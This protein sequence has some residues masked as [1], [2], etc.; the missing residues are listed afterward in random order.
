MSLLL[1]YNRS[2]DATTG[3]DFGTRN[4]SVTLRQ[5]IYLDANKRKMFRILRVMMSPEIPNVYNNGGIDTTKINL[6]NDDGATWVTCLLKTGVYTIGMLN[7][8]INNVAELQNWWKTAGDFGYE[9]NYNPATKMVYVKLDSSKLSVGTQLA[10]DFGVSQV[11]QMLGFSA[12]N[13]TF[14]TD[15]VHTA[16]LVPKLDWQGQ[17]VEV[18]CSIIQ[19]VRWVNGQI[20]SALCRIP[21][22]ASASEIIWPSA[23]NGMISPLIPASI[24]SAIQSFDFTIKNAYGRDCIFLY[25]GVSIEMEIVDV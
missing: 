24:P 4:G 7:D 3:L 15:A 13:D 6:S 19:G 18:F 17:Y 21:I 2:T 10:I 20:S 9:L 8:A 16:D 5:P 11:G 12:T 25:G 1:D 22:S 23:N 14:K